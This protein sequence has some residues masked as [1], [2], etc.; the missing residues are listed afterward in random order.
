MT[1]KN[2][3]R[4]GIGFLFVLALICCGLSVYFLN[5]LSADAGAIL[6]DNYKS[7]QYGQQILTAIDANGGPLN[8]AQFK[9][10]DTNLN[11]E[12]HNITEP[13]EGKLTDSLTAVYGQIKQSNH[14]AALQNKLHLQARQLVYGIMQLNMNAIAHKNDIATN[15]ATRATILVAFCGA[16]L[17]LVAFSFAVNFP[18]YIANPL[19]ELT[20]R[21]KEVS[22][23]NYHQQIDFKSDDEFGELGQAF[24]TMTK[25]LDEFEN[26]NLAS[27]L[28]EK[29]RIETIINSMHDAIIGLDEKLMI[30]FAN[31]VACTLIGMSA[32]QLNGRYAPDVALENDLL[33]NL[34]VNDQPKLKIFADNR[35]SF[36]SR[37]SLSVTSKGKVIGKVIILKNITEYQQLDEAKTNFIATISHELKT[38]ISSIKMSLKLLEDDRI[39][40]VNTEQRQLLENIDDDARRLL[41][42]TGELLDMAQVE[43]GKLQLNFGSTHPRNIV[44]YAVR[45]IKFIADQKQVTIK[46]KCDE[47]LPE[48]HADLDKTTWVLINLLSNAIK[49]SHEKSVVELVVK[50]R[51]SDEIEFSVQDHGKGIEEQYLSRLFERYFKVPNATADQTGTG[52]GLAIAK[53]F[54]EAQSGKIEVD[55]E[56]GSG[57]RFAFTLKRIA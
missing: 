13:G 36:Y 37:E 33:R 14:D 15:T 57:S 42:I 28:F 39:G 4:T 24:N 45:A 47:S 3:L 44:D 50:K 27:I 29:R 19:K 22:N 5:R 52:L 54:I 53:D 49:Y 6:K 40:N 43:T 35:E 9:V 31:E 23:R 7:L 12:Q 48:V 1:I 26:S 18:G 16:F 11:L 25:K 38:P 46:V 41:Q 17:F 56:L 8:D 10:I 34:L 30:I 51:H 55:S 2:K 20:A 32:E 21:I